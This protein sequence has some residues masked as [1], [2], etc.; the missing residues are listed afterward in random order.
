MSL[1]VTGF[2]IGIFVGYLHSIPPA[3]RM[4]CSSCTEDKKRERYV[5]KRIILKSVVLSDDDDSSQSEGKEETLDPKLSLL[6][7]RISDISEKRKKTKARVK[8]SVCPRKQELLDAS[9]TC[10]I[11]WEKYRD[12]ET[13]CLSSNKHC[14]HAYHFDCILPWLLKRND[15][16]LCRRNFLKG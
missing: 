14:N 7:K 5:N 2:L 11:C 1:I 6:S 15:C 13:V 8:T 3:R 16:P 12:G 4:F 10:S 9:S